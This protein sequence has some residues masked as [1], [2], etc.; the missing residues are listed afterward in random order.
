MTFKKKSLAKSTLGTVIALQVSVAAA[1][2]MIGLRI[3]LEVLT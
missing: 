3:G 1:A 2:K